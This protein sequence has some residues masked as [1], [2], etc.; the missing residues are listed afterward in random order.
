MPRSNRIRAARIGQC[1][2]AVAAL[3]LIGASFENSPFHGPVLRQLY[4]LSY[5]SA[6]KMR[7][8]TDT[9]PRPQTRK[10]AARSDEPG[11]AA[12]A[13]VPGGFYH[14]PLQVTLSH[15]S[16]A[17]IYYTLDGSPASVEARRYRK[18]IA[19]DRTTVL[20]FASLPGGREEIQTYLI[21]EPPGLPVLSVTIDPVLMWNRHAGIY[22]NPYR[23][24]RAWRRPAHA[25]YF[26]D[27]GSPAVH[28]PAELRIHGNW[29]RR[30]EKKSFKLSYATARV[31]GSDRTRVLRRADEDIAQRT[32]IIRAMA[33]DLSY[34]L[35]DELFREIFAENGG[36][37]VP[38]KKVQLLL[39]GR[40]WGLYRLHENISQAW[41]QRVHGA[42]EYDLV[43]DAGFV[44][45]EGDQ[46][47]H[48][49]IGFFQRH[50]LKETKNFERAQQLIDIEN[51]TGYWL[52]NIYAGNLDWPH[53]N[54]FAFRNRSTS[55]RWRWI[56][57]DTDTAFDV[58]KALEHDT[59]AWSTRGELRHDL[60]YGGT[61]P[62]DEVWLVST[63]IIRSLLKNESYKARFVRRFCEL[64][65]G[66]FRSDRLQSR[67]QTL[68]DD[69]TPHFQ[70]DWERWPGSE[71]AFRVGVRGVRRFI[72]ERP[73]IVL[74]HFRKSFALND[75]P[76]V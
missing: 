58:K 72:A 55:A 49:L 1:L 74:E 75:C 20:R 45:A 48:E 28:V 43:E 9:P 11:G 30:A 13:D 60:S 22:A 4:A 27:A 36:F 70:V 12:R 10:V 5:L 46:P 71:E 51:L 16:P 53:N 8:T 29:S 42:G 61:Q 14:Q 65:H 40:A 68:V 63:A 52:F 23:R 32:L 47:W 15:P 62:D 66:A 34:R 35:G 44:D 57:W 19:I 17:P 67:F 59:L 73:A 3:A 33:M 18:P 26:A 37:I 54:Y 39:N 24:G 56:S 2:L 25:E 38:G 21:G 41:L 69:L 76:A 31:S 6:A 64:R 50:D 7:V